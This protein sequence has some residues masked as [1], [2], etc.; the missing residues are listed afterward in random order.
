MSCVTVP[1]A[2]AC[3]SL[4]LCLDRAGLANLVSSLGARVVASSSGW[5]EWGDGG[6]TRAAGPSLAMHLLGVMVRREGS[7][8]VARDLAM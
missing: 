4:R 8:V 5:G 3:C 7:A 2:P 6:G 1:S